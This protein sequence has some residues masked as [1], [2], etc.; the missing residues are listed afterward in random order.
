MEETTNSFHATTVGVLTTLG[1]FALT[2]QKK[3]WIYAYRLL[4]LSSLKE[5]EM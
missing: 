4:R 1:S 3:K 5:G 2:N